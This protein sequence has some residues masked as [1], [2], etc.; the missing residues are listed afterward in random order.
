MKCPICQADVQPDDI[1]CPDCLV[2]L[3]R[4][5]AV[6][7]SPPAQPEAG[8]H[9]PP[10]QAEAA[11]PGCG[12]AVHRDE[13]VCPHCTRDLRPAADGS[14]VAPRGGSGPAAATARSPAAPERPPT[15]ART[16]RL[17]FG[18]GAATVSRGR[19][20]TLGRDPRVSTVA[21]DL[22]RFDNV[23][24]RHALVGVD[25]NGSAWV[26]DLGSTNGTFI[27]GQPVPPDT[28]ASLNEGDELRL[29]SDVTATVELLADEGSP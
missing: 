29:A 5:A 10:T 26:R 8:G 27:N 3:T 2:N 15:L 17:R 16:L 4:P 20:L 13:T 6:P 12:G 24:R 14:P 18:A 22:A 25:A 23:S 11:C 7:A 1:V 9:A 28:K 21:P 19:S